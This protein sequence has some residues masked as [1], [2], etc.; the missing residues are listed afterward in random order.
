M[1]A[2]ACSIDCFAAATSAIASRQKVQPN[3]RSSTTSVGPVSE[4]S[5]ESGGSDSAGCPLF[6]L[7]GVFIKSADAFGQFL[8]R[9]RILVL[10][11]AIRLLV[12]RDLLFRR[13]AR[14]FQ[15]QFRRDLAGRLLQRVE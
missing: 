11:P 13:G 2:P 12:E 15:R 9:H 3:E 10:H 7:A 8:D 5:G 6:E 14:A 4:R 1:F